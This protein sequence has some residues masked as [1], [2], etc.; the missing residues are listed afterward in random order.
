MAAS[1]LGASSPV[2]TVRYDEWPVVNFYIHRVPCN[3]A[4]FAQ[5]QHVFRSLTTLPADHP[6]ANDP[7]RPR[8]EN[9]FLHRCVLVVYLFGIEI[10]QALRYFQPF[11]DLYREV[12]AGFTDARLLG[13]AIIVES[14]IA[15]ALLQPVLGALQK[16]QKNRGPPRQIF[17]TS[18]AEQTVAAW[19][20]SLMTCAHATR[21]REGS[22]NETA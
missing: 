10:K 11:I 9:E 15:R 3:D 5:I 21:Q 17:S 7:E 6:L 22:A 13:T 18:N 19:I 12:Q 20:K 14:K 16:I 2:C 4:E 8:R 1:D